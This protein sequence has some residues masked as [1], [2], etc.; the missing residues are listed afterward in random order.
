MSVGFFLFHLDL[1][2]LAKIEKGLVSRHW[3]FKR[4]LTT[5]DPNK[6]KKNPT[7]PFVDITKWKTCAK[8]QQKNVK[9]YGS[10]SSSKF[11]IFQTKNL[12]SWK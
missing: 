12:V 9:L 1:E 11:S 3:F 4:L 2:L 6:I 5:Q 10:S 7:P 8:F